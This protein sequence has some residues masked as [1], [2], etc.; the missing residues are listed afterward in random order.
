MEENYKRATHFTVLRKYVL[1]PTDRGK[2]KTLLYIIIMLE[3]KSYF[4][5]KFN[6]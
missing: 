5:T 6:L 2:T 1:V 4:E 3:N